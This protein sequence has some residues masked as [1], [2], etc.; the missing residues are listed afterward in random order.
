[1][2]PVIGIFGWRIV[3]FG[4]RQMQYASPQ[5]ARSHR[6]GVCELFML[7]NAYWTEPASYANLSRL[8]I[9]PG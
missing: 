7:C 4:R 9:I 2:H 1:M 5:V 3:L 8:K 6:L